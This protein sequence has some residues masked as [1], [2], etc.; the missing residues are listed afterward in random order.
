MEA[1]VVA[2]EGGN[3]AGQEEQEGRA[4]PPKASPSLRGVWQVS[5][6]GSRLQGAYTASSHSSLHPQCPCM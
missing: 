5:P 1:G 4:I 2:G 3:R 6:P